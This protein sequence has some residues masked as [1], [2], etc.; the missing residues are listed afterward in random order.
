[1]YY[2]DKIVYKYFIPTMISYS[3]KKNKKQKDSLKERT[4]CKCG[5]INAEYLSYYLCIKF[6]DLIFNNVSK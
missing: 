6:A 5:M 4:L 1:L 2:K 3:I